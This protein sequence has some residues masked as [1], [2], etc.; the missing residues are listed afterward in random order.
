VGDGGGHVGGDGERVREIERVRY[1][2]GSDHFVECP[3]SGTRQSG[4]RFFLKS[5]LFC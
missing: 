2:N 5:F 1:N 3:R 4:F